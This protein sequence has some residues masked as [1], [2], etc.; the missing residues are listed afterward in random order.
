MDPVEVMRSTH[1]VVV[2]KVKDE[3]RACY[4]QEQFQMSLLSSSLQPGG[5][6]RI[7]QSREI[8]D[9]VFLSPE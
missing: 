5:K 9:K 8:F 2:E 1:A 4:P 6:T 3:L 7:F